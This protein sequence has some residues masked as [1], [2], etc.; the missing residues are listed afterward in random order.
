MLVQVPVMT[1][2]DGRL[3]FETP[4]GPIFAIAL[5]VVLAIGIVSETRIL[6]ALRS[7]GRERTRPAPRPGRP[8]IATTS[9]RA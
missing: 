4:I 3:A 6:S 2:M 5:L 1:M 8:G 9:P 7:R